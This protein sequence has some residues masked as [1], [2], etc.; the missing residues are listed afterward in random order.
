MEPAEKMAVN[1][2]AIAEHARVDERAQ[3]DAAAPA[4]VDARKPGPEDE[5]EEDRL[6]HRGD[7]PDAGRWKKRISSRCQ[8]ILTARKSAAAAGAR[9]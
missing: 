2:T 1:I 5:E 7:D 9:G 4:A 6:H 3:V 8:T